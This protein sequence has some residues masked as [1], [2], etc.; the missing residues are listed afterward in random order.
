MMTNIIEHAIYLPMGG[1]WER[2]EMSEFHWQ[3][4]ILNHGWAGA[5]P[6][7]EWLGAMVTHVNG[8][9]GDANWRSLDELIAEIRVRKSFVLHG[10]RHVVW[11]IAA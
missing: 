1:K 4:L 11:G 5:D 9:P 7:G 3:T 8:T 6:D 10:E 2:I